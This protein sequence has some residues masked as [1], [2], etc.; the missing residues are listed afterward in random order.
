MSS[1]ATEVLALLATEGADVAPGPAQVVLPEW[2]LWA[3]GVA[4]V[5]GAL[6]TVYIYVIR[7]IAQ[8]VHIVDEQAPVLLAI[9][10]EFQPNDGKTLADAIAAIIK[11]LDDNSRDLRII[12]VRVTELE[13]WAE[14]RFS[15]IISAL[16]TLA[17]SQRLPDD[18]PATS[19][20]DPPDAPERF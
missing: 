10:K 6:R 18:H 5:V 4:A 7:P 16:A 15:D 3:I 1:H 14:S 20:Q 12:K 17:A 9:A 19:T 2:A 8:V 13:G 11:R